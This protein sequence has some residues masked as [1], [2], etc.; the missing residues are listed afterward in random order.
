MLTELEVPPPG[1]G[2]VLVEI[3]YSG[4][5]HSQLLE[6]RG[7]R[8]PDRFLPHTIG[9]EGA[10]T[11]LEVGEGVTK[12]R[13]GDAVVLTWIRGEGADVPS[14]TYGRDGEKVNSGAISTFMRHAL[15]SENRV[16]RVPDGLGM[17]EAALLGCAVPT[18]VGMVLHS[19][20][21]EGDSIA[22]FGVGG[23]G[24]CAVMGARIVGAGRVIAVD[25]SEA[26]L[27]QALRA[28]ATDVVDARAG[29][30]APA[31]V[32]ATGG[33]GA[34][35][36]F[37]TAGQRETMEAAFRAT[38]DGGL[39]VIGGNL[40]AGET[41]AIDPM[42]LIRGRHIRGTW[43]GETK[44]D[45]D[46]PRYAQLHQQGKLDLSLLLSHEYA[47]ED[48]NEALGALEERRV[49]RALLH[50]GRRP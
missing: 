14:A 1:P 34:D 40:P 3:A 31:V 11:V 16:V 18:G 42:A 47:L 22:V 20:A 30:P 49:A 37:E 8:G 21:G 32:E 26:K 50:M 29:D 35:F 36:T 10:G 39:C 5:C 44:P 17:R 28:G 19:G 2:Q 4:V 15:I 48:A 27:E 24:L 46:I 41:I 33:R 23:V 38:R 6:V 43:G 45:E 7:D 25:V 9:H 13:R 12:A